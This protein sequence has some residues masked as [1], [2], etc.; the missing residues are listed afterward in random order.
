MEQ[1]VSGLPAIRFP[2]IQEYLIYSKAVTLDGKEMGA[3]H[4]MKAQKFAKEEY[5]QDVQCT[6]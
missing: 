5:A 1:T 3:F 2:Q 6:Q 4:S